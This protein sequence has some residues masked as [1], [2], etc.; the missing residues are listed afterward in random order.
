MRSVPGPFIATLSQAA[1]SNKATPAE[2]EG[3]GVPAATLP[4]LTLFAAAQAVRESLAILQ[5]SRSLASLQDRLLPL[6]DYY[7]I[8]RLDAQQ[9]REK[10]WDESAAELAA[11]ATNET[12]V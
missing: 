8:V 4:S 7:K 9:A 10:A 2:L 11:G 1:A 12:G 3:L 6:D 5:G